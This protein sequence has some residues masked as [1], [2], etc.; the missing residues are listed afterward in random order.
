MERLNDIH[1][2]FH[3]TLKVKSFFFPCTDFSTFLPPLRNEDQQLQ[4]FKLVDFGLNSLATFFGSFKNIVQLDLSC[5][6]GSLLLQTMNLEIL[7]AK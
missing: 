2:D 6:F 1:L 3:E 4:N 5:F 7:G